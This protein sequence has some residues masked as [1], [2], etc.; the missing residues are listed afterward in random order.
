MKKKTLINDVFQDGWKRKST[1]NKRLLFL[2]K[3]SCESTSNEHK[4]PPSSHL[5]TND[6]S[7][8]IPSVNKSHF[9]M[10]YS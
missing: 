2:Q 3:A 7:S 8:S 6:L 10:I 4:T 5:L 9:K 1:K